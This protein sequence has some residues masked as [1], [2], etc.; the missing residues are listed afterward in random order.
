MTDDPAKQ[1]WQAS[2]EIV[3]A[4]SLE[5]V[6]KGA[7]KFYRYVKWR[8]AV[9]YAACVVVVGSFG[10]YVF[11]LPHPLQKIG[12]ALIVL[13]TF[14][15]A[16]QLHHRASAEPPEKAGTMPIL[17]FT[18]AQLVRQRDALRSVFWWYLLPF[19]PGM[20]LLLLGSGQDPALAAKTPVWGRWFALAVVTGIF[21][22]T[23]WLNQ[24]AARKLQRHI[25]EIDALTG[26]NE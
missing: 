2:V 7:A 25:D 26:A 1:A 20:A 5:K 24:L 14:Y 17:A 13:A 4:L 19:V 22:G 8:N 23:W 18:R 10:R 15:V 16:W 6:R 9:E 3:G 11:T 21:G 12:S